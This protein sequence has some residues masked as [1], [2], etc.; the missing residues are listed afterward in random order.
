MILSER[1]YSVYRFYKIL[2]VNFL[3]IVSPLFFCSGG[4]KAIIKAMKSY[5]DDTE[6]QDISCQALSNLSYEN[7]KI[8]VLI[9]QLGGIK[10]VLSAMERHVDEEELQWH[11]LQTLWRLSFNDLVR[12]LIVKQ[13]G[14]D[15]IQMVMDEHPSNHKDI[16]FWG[17]LTIKHLQFPVELELEDDGDQNADLPDWLVDLL[18][19]LSLAIFFRSLY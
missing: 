4:L 11:A 13:G 16:Q 6:I 1:K 19:A 5:K 3:T 18:I 2:D 9:A 17:E 8:R 15:I 12:S 14:N 10:A 7:D